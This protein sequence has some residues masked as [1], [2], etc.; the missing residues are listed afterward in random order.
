LS[1][2][3]HPDRNRDDPHAS[4][5]FIKINSAYS[6][7]G[8]AEKR[9]KY[10]HE[11]QRLHRQSGS[12]GSQRMGPAGGRPASG[13]SK[14]RTHMHG[15]PPS[16]FRNGGWTTFKGT[17]SGP[18]QT[19]TGRGGTFGMDSTGERVNDVPHFNYDMK[20]RQHRQNEE[21]WA[22]RYRRHSHEQVQ[23]TRSV[24]L[25]LVGVGA[26]LFVTISLAAA[27]I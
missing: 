9:E 22:T 3:H 19:T 2:I 23:E 27:L 25:P 13:L 16:F 10:D 21:R 12:R 26:I 24:I 17:T 7:L 15:P 18:G 11:Q 4:K 20:Y 6:V 5:Q 14:R 8:N 1:K